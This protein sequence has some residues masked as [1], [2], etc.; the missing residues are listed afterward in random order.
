MP[1]QLI[2]F[3]TN[4][5]ILVLSF[6][7]VL[8]LIVFTEFRRFT[9]KF[10]NIGPAA[11][12]GIINRENTVMLDV[13]EQNEIKEGMIADAVHIPL[14]VFPKRVSEMDKHKAATVIVYCRSGNRSSGACR[15]LT[16]RGFEKVYNLAGGIMAWQDAHLPV[17][18][19]KN[20][21]KK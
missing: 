16:Q 7:A 17:Q 21:K 10:S 3:S 1:E 2:E 6:A 12:I 11:A 13:R 4:H 5:S 15:T 14:S 8:G 18:K 19:Q 9:Q 20:K